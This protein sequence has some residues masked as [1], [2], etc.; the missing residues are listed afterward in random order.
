MTAHHP[1]E[2][3][4]TAP[5]DRLAAQ[6]ARMG[7]F[8][9]AS[10]TTVPVDVEQLVIDTAVAAR[11]SERLFIVAASWMA[12]HH[13]FVNGRRLT[14]LARRLADASD[15]DRLASAVLGALLAVA[16][17]GAQR[18]GGPPPEALIAAGAACR[19]LAKSGLSA[20]PLFRAMER[21]PVLRE[22]MRRTTTPLFASWGLWHDDETLK[23]E[24]VRPVAW[25]VTRVPELRVRA[26]LGATLEAELLWAAVQ[27]AERQRT[28]GVGPTV[29]SVATFADASYAGTHE[30]AERLV[31][32]GLLVRERVG[33]RQVLV[34]APAAYA[35]STARASRRATRVD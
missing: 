31:R 2:T 33:V 4:E 19:S 11:A 3:R 25:I 12:A 1:H 29:Q 22:R 32:R 34:P 9:T 23:P 10:P 20:R 18:D 7:A 8:L 6:W 13:V 21:L 16:T 35:L 17:A 27:Y 28:K 30:A 15:G 24:A 5:L 14:A 26:W